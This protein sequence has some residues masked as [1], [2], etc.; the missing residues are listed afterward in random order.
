[1]FAGSI[2]VSREMERQRDEKEDLITGSLKIRRIL[3]YLNRTNCLSPQE[4]IIER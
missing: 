1:M 3:K 2:E 4:C